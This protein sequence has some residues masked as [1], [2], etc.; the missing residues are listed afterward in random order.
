MRHSPLWDRWLLV[1][2]LG[3]TAF[4]VLMA[5]LPRSGLFEP[6]HAAV[7]AAFSGAGR[8]SSPLF[9]AWV[10]GVWG[11][12]VAGFGL[13]AAFVVHRPYRQRQRWARDALAVSIGLWFVLDTGISAAYRVWVNVV[14]NA[15]ILAALAVPMIATWASF[16]GRS[17]ESTPG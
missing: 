1:V 5:L 10:Y 9:Q 15:A 17:G 14:F 6:F 16:D 11:A 12:T 8:P 7:D 4:G 2:A 3:M 13:L